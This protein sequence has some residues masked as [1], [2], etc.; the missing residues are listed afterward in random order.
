MTIVRLMSG[1]DTYQQN[2][3]A[4][5]GG[6]VSAVPHSLHITSLPP[7]MCLPSLATNSAAC[8]HSRADVFL[9]VNKQVMYTRQPCAWL[10]W[11]CKLDTGRLIIVLAA[12]SLSEV[13]QSRALFLLRYCGCLCGAHRAVCIKV[14]TESVA[15]LS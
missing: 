5:L 15:F 9:H 10:E 11:H 8:A 3:D 14:H 12:V 2:L 4:G 6:Q 7:N 1:P 13:A